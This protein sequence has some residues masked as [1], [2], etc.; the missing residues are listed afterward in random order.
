MKSRRQSHELFRRIESRCR[1]HRRVRAHSSSP[2]AAGSSASRAPLPPPRSLLPPPLFSELFDVDVNLTHEAF[3]GDWREQVRLA[4]VAGVSRAIVPGSTLA[5]SRRALAL[6]TDSSG[7]GVGL[8]TTA[9]VHPFNASSMD[10]VGAAMDDLRAQIGSSGG[11]VVALGECGLDYSDGFPPAEAQLVWFEHQL[12][13]ACEL[14]T[15]LFLHIRVSAAFDDAR[16]LLDARAAALPPVLVHCF[17]GG[18]DEL[19]WC[20]D[21]GFHVSVSGVVCKK[22]RGA[23]LRRI[24]PLIPLAKLMVETDAPY[25]GF[26]NCRAGH[27]KPKKQFPNVASA[28]PLVVDAVARAMKLPAADVAAATSA[29]ARRFFGV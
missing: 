19:R 20:L 21:S 7:C 1:Q 16:R 13:L 22:E 8:W 9:G 25:L 26:P 11:R 24:L 5:D 29:N 12:D 6:A 14:K 17:T 15:P 27:P 4:A 18:E 28:L 23:E 2:A 10:G 3:K